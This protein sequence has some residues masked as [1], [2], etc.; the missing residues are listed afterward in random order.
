M[1]VDLDDKDLTGAL[2]E[3]VLGQAGITCNKNLVPFDKRPPKETSGIRLGTPAVTTRGLKE[4]EMDVLAD[5]IDRVLRAPDSEETC[6]EAHARVL[7]LCKTFP[8]YR[9]VVARHEQMMAV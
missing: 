5:C 1:L 3:R 4:P 2:A 9:N 6:S 7:D 8:I